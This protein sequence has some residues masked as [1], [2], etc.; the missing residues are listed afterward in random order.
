MV[1]D[2]PDARGDCDLAADF[3]DEGPKDDG[4]DAAHHNVAED[5]A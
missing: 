3:V 4:D 1:A 5:S 2:G